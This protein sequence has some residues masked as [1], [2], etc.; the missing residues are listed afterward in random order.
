MS[1]NASETVPLMSLFNNISGSQ[2]T[3][4][5]L[6]VNANADNT[7]VLLE[8]AAMTNALAGLQQAISSVMA[9]QKVAP[10]QESQIED[11]IKQRIQMEEAASNRSV[12]LSSSRLRRIDASALEF[13]A[14]PTTKLGEGSYSVVYRGIYKQSY[15]PVDVA[16]KVLKFDITNLQPNESK[17]L[18]C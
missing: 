2:V 15:I 11:M 5:S 7:N 3:I 10:Q 1:A 14:T 16:V 6:T 13:E 4:G 18:N 8:L 9:G 17:M 12:D